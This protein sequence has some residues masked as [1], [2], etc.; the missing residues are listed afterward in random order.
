M[1]T[2]L[3][4]TMAIA[5]MMITAQFSNVLGEDDADARAR[6]LAELG[7]G[8]YRVEQKKGVLQFCTIVGQ[9]QVIDTGLGKASALTL[10]KRRAHISARQKFTQFMEEK[11]VAVERDEDSTKILMK[12]KQG[13][14]PKA[15]Q[16]TTI[17]NENNVAS[18]ATAIVRGMEIVAGGI[19]GDDETF[20]YIMTWT[21]ENASAAGGAQADNARGGKGKNTGREAK[22]GLTKKQKDQIKK[23]ELQDRITI[24][25]KKF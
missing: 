22:G 8:V 13:E 6:K 19:L 23:L 16:D 12:G 3:K 1:K 18:V 20:T 15:S 14:K 2:Q 24:L 9:A 11:V 7:A 17:I 4:I 10:A 5:A 25:K 21:P